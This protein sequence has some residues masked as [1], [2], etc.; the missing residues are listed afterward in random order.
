[1]TSEEYIIISTWPAYNNL[2]R[3]YTGGVFAHAD[4][5]MRPQQA[6]AHIG[7]GERMAPKCTAIIGCRSAYSRRNWVFST[8]AVAPT[9]LAN[10]GT[11]SPPPLIAVEA[12]E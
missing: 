3:V 11:K 5:T 9:V 1:M 8:E 6:S 12:R 7:G 4:D 2:N 10:W